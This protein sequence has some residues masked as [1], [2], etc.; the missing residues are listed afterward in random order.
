MY[1]KQLAMCLG[2]ASFLLS[3]LASASQEPEKKTGTPAAAVSSEIPAG[4]ASKINT[5]TLPFINFEFATWTADYV[6]AD[7][8]EYFLQ[9]VN[10]YLSFKG[11][12]F[13]EQELKKR[14]FPYLYRFRIISDMLDQIRDS[15]A[16]LAMVRRAAVDPREVNNVGCFT[17]TYSLDGEWSMLDSRFW[18]L[19]KVNTME[20]EVFQ[21]LRAM[22]INRIYRVIDAYHQSTNEL[23]SSLQTIFQNEIRRAPAF[24]TSVTTL[25]IP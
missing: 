20:Y 5:T 19:R 16:K 12:K 17:Q 23:Y 10:N 22:D 25:F 6:E 7:F 2:C 18:L 8:Q 11:W 3:S 14:F 1:S 24:L 4:Q 13:S 15:A 21:G 9:F